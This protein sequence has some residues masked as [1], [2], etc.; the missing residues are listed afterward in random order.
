VGINPESRVKVTRG[1]AP[2]NLQ[3]GGFTPVLVKVVNQSTVTKRLRIVSPQ[4]G[5]VYSGESPG[6]LTRQGQLQLKSD[7]DAS[8]DK[9]RANDRFLQVEM[10]TSPPMTSNLSGLA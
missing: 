3:Q 1:P 5:A 10:F 7:A 4:A 6:S 2:A 9:R 8:A